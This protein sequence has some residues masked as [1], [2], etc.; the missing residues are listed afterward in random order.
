M[1]EPTRTPPGINAELSRRRRWV[2]RQT[3]PDPRWRRGAIEPEGDSGTRDGRARGSRLLHRVGDG[4]SLS[5][6]GLSAAGAVLGWAVVGVATEFPL[7]WVT[8]LD[9]VASSVT[10]VMVFTIQHT[11]SRQ[12]SATQRKLDELLR[13]MPAADNR[14]IAVE[15]APDAELEALADLNLADRE[16][17]GE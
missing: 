2:Q 9:V 8:T 12:Q 15:E 13:A 4:T 16:R 17:A 6:A 11:Q 1:S 7:W 5:A 14:L 3:S 10:L